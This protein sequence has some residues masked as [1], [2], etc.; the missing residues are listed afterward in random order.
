MRIRRFLARLK[1]VFRSMPCEVSQNF[2]VSYPMGYA[3][4]KTASSGGQVLVICRIFDLSRIRRDTRQ[5]PC[6]VRGTRAGIFIGRTLRESTARRLFGGEA[7]CMH[8]RLRD[9]VLE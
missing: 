7:V 1:D 5:V 9:S 2:S 4:Q 8:H 3:T 6:R